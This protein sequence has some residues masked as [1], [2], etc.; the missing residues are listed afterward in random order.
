MKL[1]K[2]RK[3]FELTEQ[4][5]GVHFYDISASYFTNRLSSLEFFHPSKYRRG[6]YIE[7]PLF[8]SGSNLTS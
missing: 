6:M 2:A 5:K 3:V 8:V 1:Q 7:I 4:P